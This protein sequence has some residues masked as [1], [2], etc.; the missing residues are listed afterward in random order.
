MILK[1]ALCLLG[2]AYLG[3]MVEALNW[4]ISNKPIK[5]ESG[6]SILYITK[7]LFKDG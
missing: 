7:E 6:G 4:F 5:E 3:F 1:V 2:A